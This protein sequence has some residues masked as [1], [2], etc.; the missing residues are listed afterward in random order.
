MK[1]NQSKSFLRLFA[2]WNL[3]LITGSDFSLKSSV[4]SEYSGVFIQIEFQ[5]LH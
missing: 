5:P 3:A 1:Q 2:T 4:L